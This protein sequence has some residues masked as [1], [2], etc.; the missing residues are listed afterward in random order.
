VL[1][2]SL[3]AI[4]NG[5]YQLVIGDVHDD[6]T[7]IGAGACAYFHPQ[8]REMRALQDRILLGLP[9]GWRIAT[10]LPR[11]RHKD[12]CEEPP[13]I[14]IELSGLSAK[15]RDQVGAFADLQVAKEEGMLVLRHPCC[16]HWMRLCTGDVRRLTHWIFSWPR[17][18]PHAIGAGSHVPRVEMNGVILQ[19]EQWRLSRAVLAPVLGAKSF[20]LMR[21]MWQIKTQLGMP[22]HGFVLSNAQPK[23]VFVDFANFFLL[24]L[25]QELADQV[26]EIRF[27]EMLPDP[28]NLWLRDAGGKYCAEFRAGATYFYRSGR[29][30]TPEK[31]P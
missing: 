15:P 9:D 31:V 6:W 24:E 14:T 13:G 26:D 27:T 12:Y 28:N 3:D 22:D 17:V 19:R 16:A 23:P 20:H 29:V 30:Q 1:A 21:E 7:T 11:R 10:I 18:I 25:F 4:R 8:A 5:R 2:P